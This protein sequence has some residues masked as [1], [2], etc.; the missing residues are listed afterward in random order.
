MKKS[1]LFLLL[2]GYIFTAQI[3]YS[4]NQSANNQRPFRV[5]DAERIIGIEFN[6]AE[7]DSMSRDLQAQLSQ[8]EALRGLDLPNSRSPVLLFDPMQP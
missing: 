1:S 8:Y 6:E 2:L 7:R 3:A 4:Q 5:M